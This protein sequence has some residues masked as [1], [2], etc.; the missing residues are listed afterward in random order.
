M[1]Q[2]DLLPPVVWQVSS[3]LF[4]HLSEIFSRATLRQNPKI[5]L[6]V[7]FGTTNRSSAK[8][9]AQASLSWCHW[10][11]RVEY[12][13]YQEGVIDRETQFFGSRG[14]SRQNFEKTIQLRS[15]QLRLEY[16]RLIENTKESKPEPKNGRTP[17]FRSAR[18]SLNFDCR[19]I[20][21]LG[22][23]SGYQYI[24]IPIVISGSMRKNLRKSPIAK[25]L[26]SKNFWRHLLI[27]RTPDR[28][29][30]KIV[31]QLVVAPPLHGAR[32]GLP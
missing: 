17:D 12:P 16:A 4:N 8:H 24:V 20:F 30:C 5:L 7:D 3:E 19:R 9:S 15:S 23:Q 1:I 29:D 28:K 14:V 22:I 26:R 6:S 27:G 21:V 18:Y 10:A 2:D 32:R 11:L 25:K 13:V 31:K